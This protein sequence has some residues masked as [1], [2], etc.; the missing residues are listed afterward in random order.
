VSEKDWDDY[1]GDPDLTLSEKGLI[2][3]TQKLSD[4]GENFDYEDFSAHCTASNRVINVI[5]TGLQQE[6]YALMWK[7]AS[8]NKRLD[9][10]NHKENYAGWKKIMDKKNVPYTIL[11]PF[12]PEF[13]E[14]A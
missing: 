12:P 2:A 14:E 13:G 9:V 11:E 10:M 5:I 8:G 1:L 3:L 7:N 4:G 6:G